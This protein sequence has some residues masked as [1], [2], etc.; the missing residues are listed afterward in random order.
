[1]DVPLILESEYVPGWRGNKTT[2]NPLKVTLQPLTGGQ[3]AECIGFRTSEG[4][5]TSHIDM[6]RLV[7]YGVKEIRDLSAGG[8]A[9]VTGRGLVR[10]KGAGVEQLILELAAEI[11]LRNQETDLKNS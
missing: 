9:V 5:V 1:M 6:P 4:V 2:A 3:R 8:E 11:I 10:S 7:E